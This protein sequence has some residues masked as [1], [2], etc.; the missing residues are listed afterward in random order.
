MRFVWDENKAA[1]NLIKH[2]V[3][4]EEVTTVFGDSL[5]VTYPDTDHS[6]E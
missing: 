3:S 2:G 4:F 6:V 1:R 5:S